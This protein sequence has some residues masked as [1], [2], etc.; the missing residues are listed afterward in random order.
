[1]DVS[2][3]NTVVIDAIVANAGSPSAL[4]KTG[5]GEG[6][7]TS[8]SN[9]YSGGTS[10]S[11]GTLHV[12]SGAIVGPGPVSVTGGTLDVVAGRSRALALPSIAIS[13]TGAIDVNDNDLIIGNST[14]QS[15]VE[16]YVRDARNNGAWNGPGLTS[17]VARANTSGNTNLG[18]ISGA[19]YTGFGHADHLFS[20]TSYAD[21]DTLVK[22]T[23]NG[24]TNFTGTVDFDDY[25]RVDVGFNT[26]LTGW[27]NGDFNYSGSVN[28]DDYVLI[29]IAFN[30]QSGTLGRAV[31]WLSGDDRSSVGTDQPGVAKVIEHFGQFGL[32]YASALL[33]TVPEPAATLA[34]VG[35]PAL[36][37]MTR[38]RR[39]G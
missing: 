12:A 23:W 6:T 32:P 31:S 39:R 9:S 21:T 29:D 7:L 30:T 18:V 19:E 24:D 2:A 15:Q 5:A 35:V 28:F 25:V 33:A 16:T 26:N 38:R 8:A 37:G 4:T 22:Y 11:A 13:G 27:S 3:G 1:M 10:V 36:A 20:G 14:P 17:S 34:L